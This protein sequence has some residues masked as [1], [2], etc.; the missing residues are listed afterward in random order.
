MKGMTAYACIGDVDESLIDE[1]LSLFE[2]PYL[3][4][5]KEYR[6]EKRREF[7]GSPLWA[8]MICAVVSLSILSVIVMAGNGV[9]APP[10]ASG[11]VYESEIIPT[12][13][14]TETEPEETERRPAS[15]SA[16]NWVYGTYVD[17]TPQP[18]KQPEV[19]IDW[20]GYLP[21]YGSPPVIDWDHP[22]PDKPSIPGQNNSSGPIRNPNLDPNPGIP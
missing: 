3:A 1:S 16:P 8:A 2:T 12:E 17:P 21:G 7:F 5:I 4:A 6:R 13:E 9:F 22:L 10:A 20:N 15:T 11:D 19:T 18:P 14:P